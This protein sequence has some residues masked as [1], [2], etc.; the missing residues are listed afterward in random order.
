MP[1]NTQLWWLSHF[2]P[3]SNIVKWTVFIYWCMNIK[4]Y[5]LISF[6]SLVTIN[7]IKVIAFFVLIALNLWKWDHSK[8]IDCRLSLTQMKKYF[9]NHKSQC[10]G[11]S[12]RMKL[13][14]MSK[15]KKQDDENTMIHYG[16][17]MNKMTIKPIDLQY[18]F[19]F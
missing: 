9:V 3:N 1:I 17:K 8:N 5:R 4:D 6:Y 18:L 10:C 7:I 12:K 16:K 19:V 11:L 13:A 14:K 2:R 15:C